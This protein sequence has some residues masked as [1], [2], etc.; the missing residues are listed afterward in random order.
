MDTRGNL[1]NLL[2]KKDKLLKLTKTTIENYAMVVRRLGR[3]RDGSWQMDFDKARQFWENLDSVLPEEIGSILS[4]M[5]VTKISFEKSNTGDTN[6]I[7]DARAEPFYCS[8]RF[9]VAVQ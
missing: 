4:P 8:R 9:F 1:H 6:T 5:P 3:T 7:A 2:N